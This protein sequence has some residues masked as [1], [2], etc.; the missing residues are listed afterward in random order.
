MKWRHVRGIANVHCVTPL[1]DFFLRELDYVLILFLR[2][3]LTRSYFILSQNKDLLIMHHGMIKKKFR[4]R[5]FF[6]FVFF[7]TFLDNC[8]YRQC[9]NKAYIILWSWSSIFSRSY[10]TT[11]YFQKQLNSS[12]TRYITYSSLPRGIVLYSTKHNISM[13]C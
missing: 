13:C 4:R 3:K 8:P 6:F 10:H 11:V 7:C 5:S 2:T 9:G 12:I 1:H